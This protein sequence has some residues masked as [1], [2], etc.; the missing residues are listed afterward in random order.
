VNTIDTKQMQQ[1]VRSE[2]KEWKTK[3]AKAKA[4][5]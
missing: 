2:S 4:K 5:A 1:E 3:E